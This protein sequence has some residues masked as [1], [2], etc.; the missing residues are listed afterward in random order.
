MNPPKTS[1]C[2]VKKIT[3]IRIP[4]KVYLNFNLL[5]H[6]VVHAHF[7]FQNRLIPSLLP[8]SLYYL[9]YK[10]MKFSYQINYD[11]KYELQ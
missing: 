6:N 7:T 11:D 1:F 10:F 9:R 8:D 4:T 5:Y 2:W 3:P